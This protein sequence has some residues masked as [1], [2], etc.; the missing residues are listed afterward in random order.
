VKSVLHIST[1]CYPAAKAGG[2]GDVVGALPIYLPEVGYKASVII[3]KYSNKWISEQETKA[4]A[5]GKFLLGGESIVY[6]VERVVSEEQVF[7]LFVLD[8]PGKFDRASIYLA[9]NGEAFPDEAERNISFQLSILE[10]V[11]SMKKKF[12]IL[13]CHDHMTGLIPFLISHTDRYKSLE[14][15]PTFFTIHNG[16]YRGVFDW[17]K[18]KL[19]P[20]FD[21]TKSGL[22]EWDDSIHSLATAIKCATRINTVSPSYMEE[23]SED[24]DRLT[25]LIRGVSEKTLGILNGIDTNVWDPKGDPM[26]IHHLKK[27]PKLFKSKNKEALAEQ[28]GF[29]PSLP[30]VSFIGRFAY[31]KGAD[32]L[33]GAMDQILRFHKD[34]QF[35]VLGS[36]DRKIEE[37]VSALQ[38]TY[39]ENVI[40]V[41][42]YDEALAHKIYAGSDF[43]LMPSRFEPCGL[44]QMYAMRYGTT[45][46]A[47]YTGGL[48]DT[49]P[50]IGDGGNGIRFLRA[51]EQDIVYSIGRAVEFYNDKKSYLDHTKKIMKLDFSWKQSAQQYADNY[52]KT[53]NLKI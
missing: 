2:M 24:F 41:I 45:P 36:G 17:S 29:D 48:K 26:I 9:D 25:S 30:L 47:R 27:S 35:F 40:A 52:N 37:A 38:R 50:D 14:K 22:L 43:I 39:P 13:H 31:E 6:S 18:A 8:I 7:P 44:N 10:W 23:L 34:I 15:I 53:L 28:Y 21:I 46:I 4:V 49:V 1:E 19:L 51:S 11:A 32:L 33:S 20:D 16:Q 42:A 5:N 3:P 12:D